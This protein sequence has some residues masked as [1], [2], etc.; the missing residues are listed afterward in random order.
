MK[1]PVIYEKAIHMLMLPVT[2]LLTDCFVIDA[3]SMT[4]FQNSFMT[5]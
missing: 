5:Q 3:L 1:L 4:S 2:F